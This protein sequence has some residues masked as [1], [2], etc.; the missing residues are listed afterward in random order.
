MNEN[1]G[2]SGKALGVLTRHL[3]YLPEERVQ[4]LTENA[5]NAATAYA[6]A[7]ES[8]AAFDPDDAFE[9][10]FLSLIGPDEGDNQ[11]IADAMDDLMDVLFS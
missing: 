8:D 4:G 7:L 1:E 9:A 10:V 11:R 2:M 5:V 6:S 3:G